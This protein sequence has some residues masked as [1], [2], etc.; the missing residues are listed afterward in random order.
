MR[1]YIF[2]NFTSEEWELLEKGQKCLYCNLILDNFLTSSSV[3]FPICSY[4]LIAHPE[5]VREP[6]VPDEIVPPETDMMQKALALM[7]VI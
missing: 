6:R 3:A 2:I 4:H 1:I 5:P 7:V